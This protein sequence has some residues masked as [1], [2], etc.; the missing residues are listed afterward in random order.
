VDHTDKGNVRQR[1]QFWIDKYS[2]HP[3]VVKW[4]EENPPP[5]YWE[6]TPEMWAWFEMPFAPGWLTGWFDR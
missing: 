6:G 2:K 4:L 1:M 5:S 3:R